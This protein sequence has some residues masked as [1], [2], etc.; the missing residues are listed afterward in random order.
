M[1]PLTGDIYNCGSDAKKKKKE[2]TALKAAMLYALE[3]GYYVVTMRTYS[4]TLIRL[5]NSSEHHI[6]VDV[7]LADKREM[8]TSFEST[9][10]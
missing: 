10:F 2:T 1:F 6:E 5:I 8:I 3:M 7:L 9:N 4:Q